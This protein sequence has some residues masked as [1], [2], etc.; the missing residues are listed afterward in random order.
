MVKN[1]KRCLQFSLKLVNATI[2]ILGIAM[3]LYGVWMIRVWQR[4]ASDD[5][6]TASFS[7]LPWFIHVFLGLGVAL[8]GIAS[9]G[10]FAAHTA[11][12]CCLSCY[13][14][15][16][17]L[18]IISEMAVISDIFL[19]SHWEKDIPEDPSGR[20]DDFKDFVESN[21]DICE[22]VALLIILSQGCSVLLATVLR[23]LAPEEED[24]HLNIDS[25]EEQHI[26]PRVGLLNQPVQAAFPSYVLGEPLLLHNPDIWNSTVAGEEPFKNLP[27]YMQP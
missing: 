7:T 12:S 8:C 23:T 4:D 25:D 6:R 19:N 15:I 5:D 11:N 24:G 3:V 16:I 9:L 27:F 14:V 10:H 1:M 21:M 2:A 17:F 22:W 13:T 26:Q 20:F 18:L